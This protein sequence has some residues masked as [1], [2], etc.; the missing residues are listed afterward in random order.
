MES[1]ARMNQ[2]I[3]SLLIVAALLAGIL[4]F[5]E[6]GRHMGVRRLRADA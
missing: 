6:I 1:L 4:V 2:E 5:L 3:T